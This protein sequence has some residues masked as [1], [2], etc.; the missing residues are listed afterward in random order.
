[1]EVNTLLHMWPVLPFI[2]VVYYIAIFEADKDAFAIEAHLKIDH[3][4][5]WC[6]RA[7][8]IMVPAGIVCL[9][10]PSWWTLLPLLVLGAFLFSAV[11]RARL[12]KLRGLDWRYV[13]PWSNYY[14]RVF[15]AVA[16]FMEHRTW[17]WSGPRWPDLARFYHQENYKLTVDKVHEAGRLAY[18]TEITLSLLSLVVLGVIMNKN[19]P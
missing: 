14:D 9:A 1:M 12:N 15:Y 6:R 2:A 18:I 16:C 4:A 13:A 11:F 7:L 17:W 5:G 10:L 3:A 8:G 19:L